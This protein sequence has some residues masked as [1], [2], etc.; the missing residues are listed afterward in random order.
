M[1][2]EVACFDIFFGRVWGREFGWMEKD[3]LL[4]EGFPSQLVIFWS[5]SFVTMY[6]YSIFHEVFS[7]Q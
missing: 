5:I 7:V 6:R 4:L 1:L 3:D 2:Y